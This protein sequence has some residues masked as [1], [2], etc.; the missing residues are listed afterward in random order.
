MERPLVFSQVRVNNFLHWEIRYQ[1]IFGQFHSRDRV[2][3]THS[4]SL[5]KEKHSKYV[6]I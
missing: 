1:L 5:K 2:E 4:L 3:M 6:S